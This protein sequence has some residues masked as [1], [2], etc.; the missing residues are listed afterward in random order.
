MLQGLPDTPP[1]AGVLSAWEALDISIA[2]AVAGQHFGALF[3][4]SAGDV[5]LWT[6]VGVRSSAGQQEGQ[7]ALQVVPGHVAATPAEPLEEAA[8]AST[9]ASSSAASAASSSPAD[10]EEGEWGAAA[11]DWHGATDE[12][13]GERQAGWAAAQQCPPDA[14]AQQP[15]DAGGSGRGGGGGAG[16][17]AVVRDSPSEMPCSPQPGWLLQQCGG[18]K[19]CEIEEAGSSGG[20]GFMHPMHWAQ[21]REAAAAAAGSPHAG[22]A[23]HSTSTSSVDGSSCSA[24]SFLLPGMRWSSSEGSVE[25]GDSAQDGGTVATMAALPPGEAGGEACRGLQEA[26]QGAKAATGAAAVDPGAAAGVEAPA[27]P[28]YG[29][30]D[31]VAEDARQLIAGERVWLA[32]RAAQ[33]LV[34]FAPFLLLGVPLLLLASQ[35][36]STAP[37]RQGQPGASAGADEAAQTADGDVAVPPAASRLRTS[38][39]KLLLRGCRGAGAAAIKWSQWSSVRE[40]IFPE[41]RP[42]LALSSEPDSNGR[43]PARRP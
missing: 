2:A 36:G 38:A 4:G 27:L 24:H 10:D 40:D 37:Q 13:A 26:G 18:D 41:V 5:Q 6:S 30:G 1:L 16:R 43:Q 25:A 12:V 29:R 31:H 11:E 17:R 8:A 20:E 35:L 42:C 32:V 9:R 15:A 22:G 19:A 7:A 3:G 14:A 33:L 28:L 21:L 39:F 34:L 23:T